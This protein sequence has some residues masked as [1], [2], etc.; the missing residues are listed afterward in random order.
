MSKIDVSVVMP[1]WNR[2]QFLRAAID[3]V[4]AQS[5]NHE[6][7]IADDGSESPTREL[8]Q[9]FAT[10]PCIR[11]LWA[12]HCGNPAMLRNSA[13][14]VANGRYIAFLDSDDLW[15]SAKLARQLAALSLRPNCRW[16][17]TWSTWIDAQD[18]EIPVPAHGFPDSGSLV[19]SL[20]TL[21]I[22]LALPTVLIE[23]KL[24]IECGL[25]DESIGCYDDYDLYIRLAARSE[26]LLVPER[27][28][29]VRRHGSHFSRGNAYEALSARERFLGRGIEAVQSRRVR[30]RLRRMRALDLAQLAYLAAQAARPHEARSRLR[31]SAVNG[32]HM[33]RC[34]YSA[35]R[36]IWALWSR[37]ARAVVAQQ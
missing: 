15:H 36:A 8:L 33:P 37:R 10:R 4:L 24:L 2:T 32:W 27:L 34:W 5:T 25:F 31:D 23:R 17:Y 21:D 26:A 1:T 19:E 14:R 20:A 35:A 9:E 3:S 29:S 13:I 30:A 28:A 6:L 12:E 18:H 11:V 7:I 22:G 16:S